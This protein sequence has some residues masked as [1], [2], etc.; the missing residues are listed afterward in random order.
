[1]ACAALSPS[2]TLS[3][4]S[5]SWPDA[6][7]PVFHGLSVTISDGVYSL[8]G[9]N[10]AGKS[11]LLRLIS[12]ELAAQTGSVAARGTVAVVPQHPYREPDATLDTAL[13]VR[14][15]RMALRRIESGSVDEG[16]F[17]LVGDDWDIEE[18][19]VAELA[20]LGLPT[21]L[22]RRID[23]LSG[24]EA[25]LLAV[26]AA[27]VANPGVLLL[28]EPTNNLDQRARTALFGVID[29]FAGTVV[30]VSHDLELLERVDATLELYRGRLRL[31]GGPYSLY[32][33]TIDTEQQATQA[34]V[35]NAESDLRKQRR[36]LVA[37]QIK[38]D[39]RSRTA[40]KAEREKRVPKIV[41]HLRRDAAQVSAG[42]LHNAH[43]D[44][45]ADAAER[46]DD[47]REEI[48]EDRR[49]RLTMP[50][51]DVAPR[52]QIISD[53]RLPMTGPERVA[54]I[55]PNGAGKSTLL[56]ELTA[57]G[58]VH[59]AYAHVPQR[60]SFGDERRTT[61]DLLSRRHPRRSPQQVRAH[62]AHFLFAGARA[63]RTIA[64]LSGGER[65]RLALATALLADPVPRLLILDEP[66]NNL[67]IDTTE[68]LV[69]ALRD[70]RGAL[71]VVSHDPGFRD[72]IGVDRVVLL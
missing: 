40:A 17:T 41:A 42:K 34:A 49:A 38:L 10:G 47:V 6:D 23:T 62:L 50:E 32:R 58:H 53:D 19:V 21:D 72:R 52:A 37:A 3:N 2:I 27:L 8:V 61:V 30:V 65:L 20:A 55:G 9:A 54:L 12:G 69:S 43:R 22:D 33:H 39:R 70:W 35:T 59:V 36:E 60:I 64:E 15:V 46:L 4:L 16:D 68:E 71:L 66:T 28:D 13:S 25:T 29:R 45:V 24:G 11:T 5:F 14:N 7:R 63:D 44:D 31:F 1:L 18:R 57:S 51:V 48:R 67:D 56:R 26:A